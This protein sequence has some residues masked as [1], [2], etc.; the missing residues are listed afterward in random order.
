MEGDEVTKSW[1]VQG[2]EVQ[3]GHWWGN[4]EEREAP[5]A[6]AVPSGRGWSVGGAEPWLWVITARQARLRLGNSLIKDENQGLRTG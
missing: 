3:K 5:G 1:Q 6:S 4:Q 2:W